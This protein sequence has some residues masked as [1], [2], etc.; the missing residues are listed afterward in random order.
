MRRAKL[1][2]LGAGRA[3][4]RCAQRRGPCAETVGR[5]A[6]TAL[7]ECCAPTPPWCDRGVAADDHPARSRGSLRYNSLSPL[8]PSPAASRTLSLPGQPCHSRPKCQLPRSS[9]SAGARRCTTAPPDAPSAA[10]PTRA[11]APTC[12]WP[13]AGLATGARARRPPSSPSRAVR[14]PHTGWCTPTW[15]RPAHHQAVRTAAA[16]APTPRQLLALRALPSAG[17]RRTN[18][19]FPS[20]VAPPPPRPALFEAPRRT[21]RAPSA[22]LALGEPRAA[23]EQ[24]VPLDTRLGIRHLERTGLGLPGRAC[25]PHRR[26]SPR[27]AR[28]LR[29]LPDSPPYSSSR[30]RRRGLL[31]ATTPG[32]NTPALTDFPALLPEVLAV[33]A[34]ESALESPSLPVLSTT[35]P[36]PAG[37]LEAPHIGLGTDSSYLGTSSSKTKAC[38]ACIPTDVTGS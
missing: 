5:R 23:A 16:V 13:P 14:L 26:V 32:E 15:A 29:G 4:P 6:P 30:R 1:N 28:S 9:P 3:A 34:L 38:G 35:A 37:W 31:P 10:P 8:A 22:R 17:R 21:S 25:R 19:L 2:T 24:V 12:M 20:L 27:G 36:T 11:P 33:F 7:A 18:A